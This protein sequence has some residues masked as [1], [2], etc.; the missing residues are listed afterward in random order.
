MK[1]F[2]AISLIVAALVGESIG[3]K[4]K[5]EDLQ[6]NH[7][8]RS[9]ISRNTRLQRSQKNHVKFLDNL[10]NHGLAQKKL[11]N[12]AQADQSNLGKVQTKIDYTSVDTATATVCDLLECSDTFLN[13]FKN[14]AK[15]MYNE[16]AL[17]NNEAAF[18]S[19][20]VESLGYLD[21]EY[22]DILYSY[23][24]E[25]YTMSQLKS[26]LID[27]IQ[28]EMDTYFNPLPQ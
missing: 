6:K 3:I 19:G 22:L 24:S 4:T 8:Q 17:L 15:I 12:F 28:L 18:I 26:M 21:Q 13:D 7:P 16:E 2:F 20:M 1:R 9:E 11:L 14:Y 5:V 23:Y 27:E 25:E 10:K